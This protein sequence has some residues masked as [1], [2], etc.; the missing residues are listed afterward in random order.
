[1]KIKIPSGS[2]RDKI[3]PTR[4]Q[5]Y[6]VNPEAVKNLSFKVKKAGYSVEARDYIIKDFI[7]KTK[8]GI[9]S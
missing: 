7:W 6:K 8:R 5:F 4:K 1:M 3:G 2:P 9:L